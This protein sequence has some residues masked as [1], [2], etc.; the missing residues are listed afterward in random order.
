MKDLKVPINPRYLLG[1]RD[2]NKRANTHVAMSPETKKNTDFDDL[3]QYYQVPNT[4]KEQAPSRNGTI[5]SSMGKVSPSITGIGGERVSSM[6]IFQ[7]PTIPTA[8]AM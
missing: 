7:N 4:T 5:H 8:S 6:M 3:N 1:S 2:A